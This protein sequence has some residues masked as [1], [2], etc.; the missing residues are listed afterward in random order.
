MDITANEHPSITA[1]N[2]EAFSTHM[3]KF[4][5]MEDAALDGMSLKQQTGK[6]YRFPESMDKLPDDA[7]REAFRTDAN[8]LLG[9]TIP[10]DMDSFA[11]VNFKD[12]LAA[13]AE[14]DNDLVGVIKQ[15]AIDEKVPT[16]SVSKMTALF[17]GKMGEYIGAKGETMKA[18]AEEKAKADHSIAVKAC[19]DTLAGHPDFGNA[20]KLDADTV[21]LHQALTNNSKLS[22]EEANGIAE[23]L[24][25][26]EGATNP[27]LRRLMINQFAPLAKEGG[28]ENGQGGDTP[29][30]AK[31]PA[32]IMPKTA[33]ILGW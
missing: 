13:D 16:E 1:D 27:V 10:K 19:N 11:N 7:S 29:A 22:T 2:R 17:N 5:S 25:D 24:R 30:A 15:W 18:A 4:G 31:T 32:Q 8:K 21:K 6:P 23:F 33:A 14:I 12:G 9:R 26:R 3:A 28:T 20:E